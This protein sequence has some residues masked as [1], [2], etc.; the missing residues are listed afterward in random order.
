[1]TYGLSEL[2]RDGLYDILENVEDTETTW[3]QWAVDKPEYVENVSLLAL[4]LLKDG[5]E[6]LKDLS[7]THQ[8][9]GGAII[10]AY[11]RD[12]EITAAGRS[13]GR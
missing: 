12:E 8:A 5:R 3:E 10:R 7:P 9:V 2:V 1:M 4:T 6:V 11:Y 13:N